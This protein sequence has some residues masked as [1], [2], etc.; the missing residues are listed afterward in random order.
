MTNAGQARSHERFPIVELADTEASID[1]LRLRGYRLARLRRVLAQQGYGA[2]LLVDP[3]SIRYATGSRNASIFQ[4]HV[5]VRYAFIPVEGSVVLFDGES[6]RPYADRLETIAEFRP[7]RPISFFF[8]GPLLERNFA[9]WAAEIADLL[10]RHAGASARLACDC[11]HLEAI[12]ALRAQN[13]ALGDAK[14]IVEHARSIKS[15]D[16][17]A[18]MTYAITTAETG[19]ARMREALRPGMSENELWSILHQTNI[20]FGGEWIEG[21]LLSAGDRANPWQQEASARRVRLGELVAFDTDMVGPFGYCA[22]ISRTFHCGPGRPTPAQRELYKYAYEELQTNLELVRPGLTFREFSDRAWKQPP[23]FVA[24]RYTVIAHGIGMC[25][26]Y[27]AIYYSHDWEANGY[28]GVVEADMTLCVESYIG[29]ENGGEG[30]KLEE[31]V[32]VTPQGARILSRFPFE[33]SLL[34]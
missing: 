33:E 5:P 31:Q 8:A 32:H 19:M 13:I 9:L 26:E 4:M 6:Y 25:D 23:Q 22:D 17:I 27:P 10:R 11:F 28:D 20:A 3:I 15:A 30:V 21:R 24:N 7:A 29:V 18:C 12:E 14:G 34:A 1:M 16:E 2:C